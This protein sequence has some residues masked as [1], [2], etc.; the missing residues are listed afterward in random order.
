[1]GTPRALRCIRCGKLFA[2]TAGARG[3][4][5]CEAAGIG[6][7]LTVDYGERAATG[8]DSIPASPRS[9][10]R[11]ES[12]LPASPA[13][14]VTLGEGATPLVDAQQLGLGA[15]WLKDESRNPTWSFK[16][17][18]ASASVTMAKKLG[19]RV[20]A[21]S[22][23]GNA[24]AATAAYA[25]RAGL[26]CVVLTYRGAA[27]PMVTQMR[28]YGAL[29]L[30][31][32]TPEDRWRVLSAAVAKYHWWPTSVYY[33]PAVGSNP[34]GIEGYKTIAYE[35]ADSLG[36][37]AP[38]WC[39]IPVCY[40]DSLYGMWRGFEEMRALG[41]IERV[42]RFIAAEISG[43]L[44]EAMRDGLE[45]PSAL[46]H[47]ADTIAGSIRTVQATHQSVAVLRAAGGRALRISDEDMLAWQQRLARSAGVWA[48]PAA[49]ATLPAIVQLRA[50]GV[51]AESDTVVSLLTAG[52]LKDPQSTDARL[53][54][55][56]FVTGGAEDALRALKEAYGFE[57]H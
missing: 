38:D 7:N 29:L 44:A 54:P 55:A 45:Q 25:A 24:G 47:A 16:D 51:V 53:P 49:A 39:A 40:G 20:I 28:A 12:L 46:P 3:C 5:A 4:D 52:G 30:E 17:R 57:P 37:R 35:I 2:L 1:M 41:W 34:W 22:S 56:P 15:L 8:R 14:A 6:A 31:V 32:P 11:Y 10:W 23:S 26:P 42:P 19:A 50:E 18:L 27:G 43:S 21:S 33:G 48:E 13:E 36:W 9:M